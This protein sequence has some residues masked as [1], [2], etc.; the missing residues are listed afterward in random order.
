MYFATHGWNWKYDNVL[1]A[2]RVAKGAS[3]FGEFNFDVC[4]F[5]W[6]EYIKRYVLGIQKFM[7]NSGEEQ[8][9]RARKMLKMY[10]LNVRI[11]VC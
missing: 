5:T 9:P 8:L 7:L 4:S 11:T 2:I 10:A 6:D 3:D 1:E